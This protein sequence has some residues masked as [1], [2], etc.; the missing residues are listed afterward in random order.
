M[1]VVL[2]PVQTLLVDSLKVHANQIIRTRSVI[3][4]CIQGL[5]DL[6]QN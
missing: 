1:W 3:L 2:D 6:T 4:Y 5:W